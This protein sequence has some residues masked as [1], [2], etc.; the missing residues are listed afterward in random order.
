MKTYEELEAEN[1]TLLTRLT[2]I[3]M[4]VTR[5]EPVCSQKLEELLQSCEGCKGD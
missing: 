1:K 2:A 5:V 4:L 3:K